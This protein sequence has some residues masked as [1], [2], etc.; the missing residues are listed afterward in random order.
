[1]GYYN[2]IAVYAFPAG[3]PDERSS[4][5]EIPQIS[6]SNGMEA[7]FLNVPGNKQNFST[8]DPAWIQ[9]EFEEP[10]TCNTIKIDVNNSNHQANRL[11]IEVS[12]DGEHFKKVARLQPPRSG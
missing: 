8:V 10:F 9:Y 7:D 12:D 5:S 11:I 6:T 3:A 2:D 1:E 4:Y